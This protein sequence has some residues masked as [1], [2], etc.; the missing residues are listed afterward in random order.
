VK[1]ASAEHPIS[2]N[3]YDSHS[4]KADGPGNR[5]LRRSGVQ[6]R[7]NRANQSKDLKYGKNVNQ[8]SSIYPELHE[9]NLSP[10]RPEAYSRKAT[11]FGF[12]FLS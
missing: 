12:D 11:W 6:N 4:V 9:D 3:G 10:M 2:W 5:A 8:H 7:M 1:L